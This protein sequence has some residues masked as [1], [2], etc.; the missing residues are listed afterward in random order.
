VEAE[1]VAELVRAALLLRE[2][3]PSAPDA[4]VTKVTSA[5]RSAAES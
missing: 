5:G 3:G 1:S 2:A 4:P